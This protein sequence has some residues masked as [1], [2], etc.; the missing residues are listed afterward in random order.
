MKSYRRY[1]KKQAYH[2]PKERLVIE[3]I[4]ATNPRVFKKS[5]K[6]VNEGILDFVTGL[7]SS[8]L[9]LF[10]VELDESTASSEAASSKIISDN[11]NNG[12]SNGKISPEDLGLSADA[13]DVKIVDVVP[14][15]EKGKEFVRKA[16]AVS[17]S[18]ALSGVY[19]KISE[20]E[21]VPAFPSQ[22]NVNEK[23]RDDMIWSLLI[24]QSGAAAKDAATT[25]AMA[26]EMEKYKPQVSTALEGVGMMKG[27]ALSLKNT[28][29]DLGDLGNTAR[30]VTPG[31]VAQLAAS[32]AQKLSDSG[33]EGETAKIIDFCAAY[34]QK[35]G[36][37]IQTGNIGYLPSGDQKGDVGKAA[38]GAAKRSTGKE[39]PGELNLKDVGVDMQ[40]LDAEGAELS[41][42]DK[43]IFDEEFM[44][45]EKGMANAES[46]MSKGAKE[47]QAEVNNA[48]GMSKVAIAGLSEMGIEGDTFEELVKTVA[49]QKDMLEKMKQEQEKLQSAMEG[50]SAGKG[51]I[52]DRLSRT[53][54]MFAVGTG[55][56][57]AFGAAAV[58]SVWGAGAGAT[59]TTPAVVAALPGISATTSV[60][61]IGGAIAHMAASGAGLESTYA[62]GTLMGVSAG[63]WLL[64]GK[65]LLALLIAWAVAKGIIWLAAKLLDKDEEWQATMKD[66]LFN[67][68]IGLIAKASK[69]VLGLFWSGIKLVWEKGIEAAKGLVGWLKKKFSKN[70]SFNR[71]LHKPT[72]NDIQSLVEYYDMISS[73]K[74]SCN[75][76]QNCMYVMAS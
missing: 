1:A 7:F 75:V 71:N 40:P 19:S 21:G 4:L 15:T 41:Q 9:A 73:F 55:A 35:N 49:E 28:V 14:K 66:K 2:M 26:E 27:F 36:F 63:T 44:P 37:S 25:E 12:I 38:K 6:K 42:S 58:S 47:A 53:I 24:E 23:F 69:K 8:I 33:I 61:G 18:E 39:K 43:G 50:I 17:A 46:E 67:Y 34:A 76:F 52:K 20:L 68:S 60:S 13:D 11:I 32:V 59:I 56:V 30:P 64:I 16:I 70:E 72:K 31:D 65:I 62:A 10:G 54:G 22:K 5:S 57:G 48:E 29:P 45:T 74:V 51:S 3:S